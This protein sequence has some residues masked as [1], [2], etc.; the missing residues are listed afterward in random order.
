[1]TARTWIR[2]LFARPTVARAAKPRTGYRLT[3]E[4][5]ETRYVPSTLVVTNLSDTGVSGD[6]SLRGEIAAAASGDT[7]TFADSLA[8]QTIMLDP[9]KGQ[10]ELSKDLTINGLGAD[11]LTISGGDATRVFQVD[12][13][14]TDTIAMLTIAHGSADG[15][16]DGNLGGGGIINFGTLTLDHCTLSSNH[17]DG[18]PYGGGGIFNV[19]GSSSLTIHYSTLSHNHADGP[20][21][22]PIFGAG[23][24]AIDNYGTLSI[25]HSTLSHNH[26][27]YSNGAGAIANSFGSAVLTHTT[28]SHNH[29]NHSGTGGGAIFNFFGTVAI[30]NSTL[31]DNH[32]D[33]AGAGGGGIVNWGTTVTLD[34]CTVSGNHAEGSKGGGIANIL[35]GTLSLVYSK[36][37]DNKAALGDDLFNDA[38]H[39]STITLD[40][41]TVCE[42]VDG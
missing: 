12:Y 42:R 6:G 23:G 11:Q 41:S 5:L 28:L 2:H 38:S 3:L 32:A 7:I 40:H 18:A 22:G 34:H 10:L 26:A 39:G 36:V 17:A 21:G 9:A 20:A 37:C 15:S 30:D 1:M 35:G 4:S 24:G 29:A 19:Y 25:D 14:H 27:D 31:S 13:G 16:A 8:G 33:Q